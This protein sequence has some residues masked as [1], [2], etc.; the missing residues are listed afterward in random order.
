MLLL[1]PFGRSA[2]IILWHIAIGRLVHDERNANERCPQKHKFLVKQ[3]C[4]TIQCN[5][6]N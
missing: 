1:P 2:A 6:R 5:L 4:V 3:A